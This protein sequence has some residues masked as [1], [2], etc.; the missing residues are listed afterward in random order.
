MIRV[1]TSV[2]IQDSDQFRMPDLYANHGTL[3]C[4]ERKGVGV[5]D[6]SDLPGVIKFV[7]PDPHGSALIWLSWIRVRVGECGSGYRSK[8]IYQK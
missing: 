4:T 2:T 8:K 7:E 3:L 5:Y 6:L 1:L